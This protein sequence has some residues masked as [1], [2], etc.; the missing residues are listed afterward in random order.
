MASSVIESFADVLSAYNP[1]K[2]QSRN[3]MSKY[4]IAKLVGM[5]LEQL[6]RGC[7]PTVD[8]KKVK[9]SNIH[10]IVHAELYQRKMPFMIVRTMPNGIKEYWRIEDMI[11][12]GYNNDV[13]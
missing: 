3:I 6:A 13:V 1:S 9:Y 10:D 11:I 5:R 7:E 12:P 8:T 4:E 2:N